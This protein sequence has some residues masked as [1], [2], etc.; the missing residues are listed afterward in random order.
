MA[1]K[2]TFA[3]GEYY[4]IY[5]R[6]VEKRDIYLNK[7]DYE[8]F[9]ALLYLCN[10]AENL[11]LRDFPIY[12]EEVFSIRR[13]AS[14]VDICAYCLMPNHFHLLLKEK[15]E[16]G[17]S[18]FIQ[19]L[20]TAYAMYFNAL[21]DRTGSLFQGPFKSKHADEDQ[22]LKYLISYIHLNPIKLIEPTWR[23]TGI[24]DRKKAEQ[25]L[26]EYKYSSYRDFN[27]IQRPQNSIIAKGSLP[28]YFGVPTSFKENIRDWLEYQWDH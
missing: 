23:E 9:I 19:R 16:G 10:T 1:R 11:R 13:Q 8:R 28:N 27:G 22:Y 12:S 2:K 14:L 20:S 18:A 26:N 15:K 6:G 21:N 24:S 4:H 7:A 25:Y 5:N 3:E 17:I